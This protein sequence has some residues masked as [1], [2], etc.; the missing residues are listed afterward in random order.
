MLRD[1]CL[2]C[3]SVTLVYCGEKVGW[4]KMPLGKEVGLGPGDI[5]LNGNPAPPRKGLQQAPTCRPM[6]NMAK[7]SPISASAELLLH[8]PIYWQLS[9]L[10][11]SATE[12]NKNVY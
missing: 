8:Q 6:S 12:W 10:S 4:I 1:G 3:L 9:S 5:V 2:S 7:R 11:I